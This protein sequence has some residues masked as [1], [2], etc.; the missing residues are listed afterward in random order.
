M[1]APPSELSLIFFSSYDVC[2]LPQQETLARA[3]M[4]AIHIENK[5]QLDKI[6]KEAGG[7]LVIID[8]HAT[9]CGPCRQ[10]G[11]KFEAFSETYPDVVFLKVDVD[12][13]EDVPEGYEINVMPTFIFIKHGQ[14]VDNFSG[15][16]AAKLEEM[17][18]KNK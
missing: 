4:P 10:I 3:T 12:E 1:S 7:K 17:I 14:P 11:P 13:A 18:K 2:C 15:A 6:L 16:N 9:W 5:P 8:F